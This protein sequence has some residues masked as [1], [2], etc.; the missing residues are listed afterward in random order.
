MLFWVVSSSQE[1]YSRVEVIA[2]KQNCEQ[3]LVGILDL[4]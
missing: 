3:N 2:V 4:F 1:D